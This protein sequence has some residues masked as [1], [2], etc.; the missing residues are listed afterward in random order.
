MPRGCGSAIP[1]VNDF[2]R[3]M[4]FD[5]IRA[6]PAYARLD[7]FDAED[8]TGPPNQET[9]AIWRAILLG[10]EPRFRRTRK[11][12]KHLP[13]PPRCKL[14]ATPFEGGL[15]PLMRA[16]GRRRWSGNPKYCAYCFHAIEALHGGAEI[17]CS[18]LFADVRG[19]TTMAEKISPDAFSR[20][21]DRFYRV[22][23]DIHVERNAIIDKYDCD[24]RCAVLI[25]AVA[26]EAH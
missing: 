24:E 22:P 12:M 2:G 25:P 10:T 6:T 16:I 1:V 13:S 19:S 23:S 3:R 17:D 8:V 20:L 21:I 9:E 18:M 11:I 15:A 14:C 7:M 4:P 5:R 26:H